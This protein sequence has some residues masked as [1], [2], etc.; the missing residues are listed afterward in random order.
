MERG[1]GIRGKN[2]LPKTFVP[3]STME[4]NV[5]H[6]PTTPRVAAGSPFRAQFVS[7][8]PQSRFINLLRLYHDLLLRSSCEISHPSR[9]RSINS[10]QSST[11]I[12]RTSKRLTTDMQESMWARLRDS[13]HGVH[14]IHASLPTYFPAFLYEATFTHSLFRRSHISFHLSLSSCHL[15]L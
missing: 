2:L 9:E 3:Q 10:L 4:I 7:L 1:S 5:T 15:Y 14:A 11:P 12:R 13:C 6:Q 8:P